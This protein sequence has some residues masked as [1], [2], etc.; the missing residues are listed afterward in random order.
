[1]INKPN[2]SERT[3]LKRFRSA[4]KAALISNFDPRNDIL[5]AVFIYVVLYVRKND[6]FLS[7]EGQ[8]KDSGHCAMYLALQVDI[9]KACIFFF[10]FLFFFK[11]C[12]RYFL[13]MA[14]MHQWTGCV[15]RPHISDDLYPETRNW[16][17]PQNFLHAAQR[18][19][20]I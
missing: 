10:L 7:L 15:S 13:T 1:M 9:L 12:N 17:S 3:R 11:E 8:R 18:S 20:P 19:H 2:V 14:T 16:T 5:R 4:L 6:I